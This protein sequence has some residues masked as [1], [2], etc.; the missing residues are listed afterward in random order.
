MLSNNNINDILTAAR[1]SDA[2]VSENDIIF[3]VL[4]DNLS[5]KAL[6]YKSAYGCEYDGSNVRNFLATKRIKTTMD[7][8]RPYG[9]GVEKTKTISRE[10]NQ[11]ELI[12]MLSDIDE[13]IA[14]GDV[15]KG[16][17]LKMKM[18][19]RV[20]LQDKFDMD[21]NDDANR[22]IVIVP[23]KHDYICPHTNRECSKMPTK[24]ACIKYYGLTDENGDTGKKDRRKPD[25]SEMILD[26]DKR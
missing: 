5:D 1:S 15:D 18:D 6:A 9:V 17:G 8:A 22:H 10:E 13:A 16:A 26:L 25:N 3:L 12:K 24:E 20:K 19:I 21:E 14:D 23:Q 2:S 11:E 4:C 7:A